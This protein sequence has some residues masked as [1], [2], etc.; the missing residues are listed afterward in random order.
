MAKKL[1][2]VNDLE[3]GIV[4]R[5]RSTYTYIQKVQEKDIFTKMHEKEKENSGLG[6]LGYGILMIIK[7]DW[8]YHLFYV[9]ID[10][11]T[12]QEISSYNRLGDGS[13]VPFKTLKVS[14]FL[15]T[16]ESSVEDI[17]FRENIKNREKIKKHKYYEEVEITELRFVE[18]QL[19]IRYC[20]LHVRKSVRTADHYF[21]FIDRN[22]FVGL[23]E[24][25]E[26]RVIREGELDI[27]SQS[28]S[29]LECI[30]DGVYLKKG[31]R[32]LSKKERATLLMN[33]KNRYSIDCN[34]FL[35]GN[36]Y[37]DDDFSNILRLSEIFDDKEKIKE[38]LR[39]CIS[40]KYEYFPSI[41]LK[42]ESNLANI[43]LLNMERLNVNHVSLGWINRNMDKL[44]EEVRNK[45]VTEMDSQIN[46][47]INV[48]DKIQGIN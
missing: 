6:L 29:E 11:M 23:L 15:E 14:D 22:C 12:S 1:V 18:E 45:V 27:V 3:E 30:G 33:Y 2:T 26:E 20:T 10:E 9:P 13:R 4:Y 21:N 28:E 39:G 38:I 24:D 46:S 34:L 7:K 5:Y 44:G 48:R 36:I 37:E 8:A 40:E 31:R 32:D 43:S 35:S 41:V 19:D 25:I 47:L 42:T 17:Y 16:T